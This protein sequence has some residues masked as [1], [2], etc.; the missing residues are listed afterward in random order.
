MIHYP[1]LGETLETT[2][3][4]VEKKILFL[5]ITK[6]FMLESM[7]IKCK[8]SECKIG[9]ITYSE[10]Q[11]RKGKNISEGNNLEAE[12]FYFIMKSRAKVTKI[13][14]NN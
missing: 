6:D 8:E 4:A 12:K 2:V 3:I 1:K 10:P 14:D 9:Q 11:K 7:N 5:E 13:K